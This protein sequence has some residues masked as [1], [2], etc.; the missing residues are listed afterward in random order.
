MYTVSMIFWN[1]FFCLFTA[2][3]R[4]NKSIHLYSLL[5]FEIKFNKDTNLIHNLPESPVY[6]TR[7]CTRRTP[8][9]WGKKLEKTTGPLENTHPKN[10][11]I[12]Q[13]LILPEFIV[14]IKYSNIDRFKNESS[15]HPKYSYMKFTNLTQ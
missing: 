9:S 7:Q 2:W 6:S 15:M 10:A 1:L 4:F 13:S 14:H 11:E 8:Q 3:V 12:Y 5:T